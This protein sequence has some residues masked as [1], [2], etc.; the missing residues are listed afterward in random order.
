[1]RG[2]KFNNTAKPRNRAHIASKVQ[3]QT[4][5]FSWNEKTKNRIKNSAS[6]TQQD[7]NLQD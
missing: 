3:V 1:M 4:L 2:S 5:T 7:L 6:D